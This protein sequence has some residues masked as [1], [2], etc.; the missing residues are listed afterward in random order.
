[1]YGAINIKTLFPLPY[2]NNLIVYIFNSVKY[3]PDQHYIYFQYLS[4]E[5][6]L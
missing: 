4:R 5:Y 2:F 3:N 1:M 6:P